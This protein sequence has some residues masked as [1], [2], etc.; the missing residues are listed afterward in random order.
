MIT[1][2]KFSR[3]EVFGIGAAGLAAAYLPSI[4]LGSSQGSKKRPRNVIFCVSDG[5]SAGVP[6]MLDQLLETVHGRPSFWKRL[7]GNAEV[8]IGVQS[9]GSLSSLVTDSSAASSAWGSGR[10]IVN[11]QVNV[12]PDG[13]RLTPLYEVLRDRAKLK[14]GLVTTATITHATPAGFAVS[15][16]SRD[17][18]AQIAEKYLSLGVDVL[19]GGGDRFFSPAQRKD[20]RDLY[21][22]FAR[23][24]YAVAKDRSSMNAI[25]R[26]SKALGVFSSSHVPYEVDRLNQPGL[27]RSVPSLKEMAQKAVEL[28]Q[29]ARNGF[30]LQVEGARVDHAAHG[31]DPAGILYDQWAFDDAVEAMVD[32]A[33]K[34]GDTL[35]IVTTDHGNANPGLIGAGD[36]YFDSTAGLQK[37]AEAKASFPTLLQLAGAKPSASQLQDVVRDRLGIGLASDE[38]AFVARSLAG[39]GELRNINFYKGAS[40]ALAMV[41]GNHYHIGWSG[42]AHSSDW[43]PFFAI[44]PG[45]AAFC[46]GW[47][48]NNTVFDRLLKL[49][50][51]RFQNPP[52]MTREEMLRHLG[53]QR[54]ALGRAVAGHWLA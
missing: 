5:M 10:K 50:G 39:D 37:L 54:Q 13:T 35:V 22:D 48:E 3:R 36:E 1:M 18:E 11:G 47:F 41:L 17:E 31:N 29:D 6:S 53:R 9:T 8:V 7:A 45:S 46:G 12:F 20:G 43:T 15:H 33:Q 16:P 32:W 30:I 25:R 51:V 52:Q 42:P 23:A 24:G 26:G 2:G 34:R 19:F 21:A 49:Y 28:L 40:A 27:L 44:G 38:A 14:T 4:A